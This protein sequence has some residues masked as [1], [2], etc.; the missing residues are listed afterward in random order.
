[1]DLK[2]EII[3]TGKYVL[4]GLVLA[5]IIN[6]GLGYALETEKPVMAVVSNSMVPT[7]YKGDL[8]VV[9]GV[10]PEKLEKGDIIVYQNP[11]RNIPIVHRVVD[12]EDHGGYRYFYTKGDHNLRT[13]QA[14]GIAPPVREDLIK[15][16]V[17]LIIPKLGWFRVILT[18]FAGSVR[19]PVRG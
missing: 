19:T 1:M 16:R 18:E 5:F 17:I 2:K 6:Q 10:D 11:Y 7:F 15:G 9:K 3:E 14:F 13:D 12:I 4:L 8:V